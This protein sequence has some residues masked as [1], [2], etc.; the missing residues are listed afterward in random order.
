MGEGRSYEQSETFVLCTV[1]LGF[2]FVS[3]FVETLFEK[4]EARFGKLKYK[5]FIT[6]FHKAKDERTLHASHSRPLARPSR[7]PPGAR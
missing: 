1:F 3:L 7:P 4:I 6:C 5:G 2:L